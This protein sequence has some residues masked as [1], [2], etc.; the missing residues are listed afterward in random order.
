[1]F[2]FF[3]FKT[4]WFI[5][6]LLEKI[7]LNM[8]SLNLMTP[9]LFLQLFSLFCH[10]WEISNFFLSSINFISFNAKK[11][12][13]CCYIMVNDKWIIKRPK[14][15]SYCAINCGETDNDISLK[16]LVFELLILGWRH[17]WKW[18]VYHTDHKSMPQNCWVSY[19][20]PAICV[21]REENDI[22]IVKPC[23]HKAAGSGINEIIF[24]NFSW[25]YF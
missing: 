25:T 22:N 20:S 13:L 1:M 21:K 17:I 9:T 12:E 5:T 8:M 10:F 6:L 18:Q 14:F 15:E 4:T 16:F 24:S 2:F 19:R 11:M 7:K 3:S 23:I